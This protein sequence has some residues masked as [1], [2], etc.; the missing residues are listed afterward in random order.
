MNTDEKII[1]VALRH[2]S[3]S[4]Y[5]GTSLAMIAEDVG[6]K[7]PSIYN[8]FKNKEDL[9]ISVSEYVLNE[10][11]QLLKNVIDL[12]E[13]QS[14]KSILKNA[15]IDTS[16]YLG[17]EESGKFYMHFLLFPPPDLKAQIHRSFL[18]FEKKCDEVLSIIFKRGIVSGE[19]RPLSIRECLDAY[20]C[21]MDGITSQ[22]FYYD[23]QTLINKRES[24]WNIF[25]QGI[26][27]GNDN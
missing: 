6:I 3:T 17:M 20:Y 10:Y 1:R 27:G 5:T 21:F 12:D 16:D 14:V 8:H 25:W 15:M 24:A 13:D 11:F 9:F 26:K 4:G 18:T 23:E 2:F 19:I 22:W 7:K